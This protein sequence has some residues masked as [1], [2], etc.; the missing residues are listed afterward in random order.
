VH[1]AGGSAGDRV[2]SGIAH[3][4]AAREALDVERVDL[5][6]RGDHDSVPCGQV[7]GNALTDAH[8]DPSATVVTH[9]ARNRRAV[10][11]PHAATL[12]LTISARGKSTPDLC[13]VTSLTS[14]PLPA[15]VAASAAEAQ[16]ATPRA[17]TTPAVSL[18]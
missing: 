5:T 6:G 13:R 14:H 7:N 12:T 8:A 10:T 3:D 18:P 4:D 17:D 9:T 2:L 15:T 16:G 1:P 11:T